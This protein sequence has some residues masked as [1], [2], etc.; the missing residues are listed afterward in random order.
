MNES[1]QRV[2]VTLGTEATYR[3]SIAGRVDPKSID[4]LA[5]MNVESAKGEGSDR[6]DTTTLVGRVSDQAQLIGLLNTLYE[7]RLPLLTVQMLPPGTKTPSKLEGE[8]P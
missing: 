4:R 1:N 6:R 8:K 5:G 3:V 2:L 7:M